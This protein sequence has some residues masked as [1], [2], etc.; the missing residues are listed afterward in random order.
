MRFQVFVKAFANVEF[1]A[2]SAKK[3]Y[4]ATGA[5]GQIDSLYSIL[6][7]A[8]YQKQVDI[9]YTHEFFV[10]DTVVATI[11]NNVYEFKPNGSNSC[12]NFHVRV[13]GDDVLP[14]ISP[15]RYLCVQPGI[16]ATV[17]FE[18]GLTLGKTSTFKFNVYT[19]DPEGCVALSI[20]ENRIYVF[21]D[22]AVVTPQAECSARGKAWSTEKIVEYVPVTSPSTE[23]EVSYVYQTANE[24]Q[25]VLIAINDAHHQEEQFVLSVTETQC[26]SPVVTLFGKVYFFKNK[27]QPISFRIRVQTTLIS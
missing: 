10:N 27:V 5:G 25:V 12:Y 20:G 24:F 13:F 8:N 21:H 16:N 11:S 15:K 4:M 2:V 23:A 3:F 19:G 18:R 22:S 9:D 17:S 26:S 1:T 7:E 14:T 6:L